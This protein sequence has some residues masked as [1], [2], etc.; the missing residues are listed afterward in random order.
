MSHNLRSILLW[1]ETLCTLAVIRPHLL[2]ELHRL[3]YGQMPNDWHLYMR[4]HLDI[5]TRHKIR[6]IKALREEYGWDAGGLKVNSA[7]NRDGGLVT[8]SKLNTSYGMEQGTHHCRLWRLLPR[9]I[10]ARQECS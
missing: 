8:L 5:P 4:S 10:R 1:L 7:R 6:L 3:F 9:H 2:F